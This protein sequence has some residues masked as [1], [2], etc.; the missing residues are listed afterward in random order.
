MS[1]DPNPLSTGIVEE[2]KHSL[3]VKRKIRHVYD[4]AA[5]Y[6]IAV[7]GVGVI[8]MMLLLFVFLMAEVQPLF[9]SAS[10]ASRTLI[11]LP[12][13][14]AVEPLHLAVDEQNQSVVRIDAQG[15]AVFI[16][17]DSGEVTA[18]LTLPVPSGRRI[19]TLV[20]DA[21]ENGMF[22]YGLDDGGVYVAQYVWDTEFVNGDG[23]PI[24][25]PAIE[26]P[27]GQGEIFSAD[28]GR[29]AT[30]AIHA[31]EEDFLLAAT[32][33]AGRLKI[34]ER[35]T[36]RNLFS[37]FGGSL[38]PS[39]FRQVSS[40]VEIE[41]GAAEHLL[42]G[43]D[44]R[45]LYAIANSGQA[46][47]YD[48]R[49]LMETQVLDVYSTAQLVS[50]DA[51]LSSV[52]LLTG[53]LSLLV[54]DTAGKVGQW[55]VV[56]SKGNTELVSVRDFMGDNSPLAVIAVEQR[57]KNFLTVSESGYLSLVNATS[58]KKA[59]S[60]S[61]FSQSAIAAATLSPRGDGLVME[62]SGGGIGSWF[63]NNPHPE[64]SFSALWN[65]V[66]YE[67]Y[68]E[69]AYVWQ[70]SA[71]S[72]DFEPKYS[73][74]PLSFGTLKAAFY[75]ML[76]AAP[77]AICGA[78][79]TGYFMAPALRRKVK[80]LIELMEALPTVVLGFLA[81]L[82]LAPFVET[83]LLGVLSLL[84]LLP[85]GILLFSFIWS[86]MPKSIR[87]LVP[88][89]WEAILLI[90]VVV[91]IGLLSL[92]LANPLEALMFGGDL[93]QWLSQELGISYDQ[94]NAMVVGFAMGFAVIPTI[95]S[96]AEDAVFTVPRH[97][98]DGSLAL[99]ATSWQSLYHVILPT[100]SPGIFSALM[101]GFGRAVGETM[102]I[103]MATGNT[104]IM[105]VN[106]F[107]G[108]RTLAATIAIEVPESAVSS[109]HYRILFL[110][111]MVLFLFTFV[112]NT[113]AEIV[114]QQLRRKYSSI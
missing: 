61:S 88:D 9:Q 68:P 30:L 92:A 67:S 17:L 57:R 37:G 108:M 19:S 36:P 18:E 93:R 35:E 13:I 47:V 28:F 8:A 89:G 69:P 48:L 82:W 72:S 3:R 24:L 107:E 27:Y 81:G 33:E 83:Q 39:N 113:I 46:R 109:T 101:I 14:T 65:R 42:V 79:Y 52:Q 49:K 73:L 15:A 99:G 85:V 20:V 44:R 50:S 94:R 100:A 58:R 87:Y 77:L 63:I 6:G 7:G 84:L 43:G 66:W 38:E 110:A 90:P 55:F 25:I 78:V 74:T 70:S 96:I 104:P 45:L 51:E 22:A 1:K 95:Y 21:T 114:R 54:A 106:M 91:L 105:D 102:I 10:I 62:T 29:V 111:A 71:A 60:E 98:S 112:V 86:Q 40:E 5:S 12:R 75:A 56:R 2:N 76:I 32:N 4:R 31:N 59:L 11:E 26:Y 41:F 64:I 23:E 16:D 103:L 53:G 80:P 34:L 97:L